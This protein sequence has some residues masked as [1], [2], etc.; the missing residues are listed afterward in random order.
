LKKKKWYLTTAILS[1]YFF[2]ACS[3]GD[4]GGIT[5]TT[6]PP[7]AKV[8]QFVDAPVSGLDYETSGGLKGVTDANGYFAYY[9]NDIVTFKIGD[10]IVGSTNVMDGERYVTPNDLIADNLI[11]GIDEK[12][13]IQISSLLIALDSDKNPNNGIQISTEV[14][15]RF[16]GISAKLDEDDLSIKKVYVDVDGDGVKEDLY[17]DVIKVYEDQAKAHYIETLKLLTLTA[18]QNIEKITFYPSDKPYLSCFITNL[19]LST[20]QFSYEC[21]DNVG[22]IAESNTLSLD[23]D[24]SNG[25]IYLVNQ[26]GNKNTLLEVDHDSLCYITPESSKI[27]FIPKLTDTAA[28]LV[29]IYNYISPNANKFEY[30][31]SSIDGLFSGMVQKYYLTD[32]GYYVGVNYAFDPALQSG[33]CASDPSKVFDPNCYTPFI[34]YVFKLTYE[35]F[36]G[37]YSCLLLPGSGIEYTYSYEYPTLV[38]LNKP[39]STGEGEITFLEVNTNLNLGLT[40]ISLIK[41]GV[42]S[43]FN[44]LITQEKHKDLEPVTYGLAAENYGPM[45]QTSDLNTLSFDEELANNFSGMNVTNFYFVMPKDTNNYIY[46]EL[47]LGDFSS[48]N[49]PSIINLINSL[50]FPSSDVQSLCPQF[51]LYGN[52]IQ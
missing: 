41:N 44:I 5:A 37:S 48:E 10:L 9:P 50:Q 29:D 8:A 12:K 33:S 35:K 30:A 31:F 32:K 25:L 18:L 22:L 28:N 15:S 6:P 49:I 1:G 40:N 36:E 19:N 21:R 17:N 26:D 23:E 13:I 42:A 46:G 34:L 16:K 11:R 45:Y 27:C 2:M 20:G 39:Y 4:G 38:E 47:N 43:S 14:K 51:E 24:I 7:G 52:V 3:D